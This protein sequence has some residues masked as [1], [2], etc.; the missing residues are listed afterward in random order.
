MKISSKTLKCLGLGKKG[1][2]VCVWGEGR[3]K[4][5]NRLEAKGPRCYDTTRTGHN[6]DRHNLDRRNPDRT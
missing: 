6:P 4:L 5:Y 3:V 2:M 1:F